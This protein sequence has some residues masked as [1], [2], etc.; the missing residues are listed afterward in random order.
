M[1]ESLGDGHPA[2]SLRAETLH[3]SL[4]S[5][6]EHPFEIQD[7][8]VAETGA[9]DRRHEKSAAVSSTR[10]ENGQPHCTTIDTVGMHDGGHLLSLEIE[11]LGVER[12][13]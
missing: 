6:Q 10:G 8:P 12:Q 11:Q 13:R 2:L 4:Q 1:L 3:R 7:H 5:V 9:R